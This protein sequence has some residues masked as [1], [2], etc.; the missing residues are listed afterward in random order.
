M[1]VRALAEKAE[2]SP[3]QL[4]KI[5]R[6]L[7]TP[8]RETLEKIAYAINVDKHELFVLGGMVDADIRDELMRGMKLYVGNGQT[9][10]PDV[11]YERDGQVYAFEVKSKPLEAQL[12]D[13]VKEYSDGLDK[14]D[15]DFIAKEMR[16]A[17]E[18]TIKRLDRKG[19]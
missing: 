12:R 15:V 6:G 4:S 11:I 5:E 10:S 16:A 19:R 2:I 7:S 17:F 9:I 13:I 1:S 3:S 14:E 8:S 18:L